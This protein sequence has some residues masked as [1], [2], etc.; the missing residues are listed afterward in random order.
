MMKTRWRA[1]FLHALEVDVSFAPDVIVA[2]TVLH[3]VC[4]SNDDVLA[5]DDMGPGEHGVGG[6]A[7]ETA[8]GSAWRDNLAEEF[9]VL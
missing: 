2:C 1:I 7:A 6:F 4:L 8:S 3:N 5:V 9:A